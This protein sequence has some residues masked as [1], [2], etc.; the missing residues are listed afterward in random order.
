LNRIGDVK[1]FEHLKHLRNPI[2]M[3]DK[4]KKLYEE[5]KREDLL[6]NAKMLW[7]LREEGGFFDETQIQ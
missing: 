5:H 2:K 1:T 7:I 4:V 3:W 6:L